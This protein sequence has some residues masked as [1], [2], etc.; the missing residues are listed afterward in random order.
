MRKENKKKVDKKKRKGKEK[1]E[2]KEE[3][4]KRKKENGRRSVAPLNGERKGKETM[5]CTRPNEEGKFEEG[6]PRGKGGTTLLDI[7][8]EL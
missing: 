4:K 8:I 2:Q 1:R 6:T 3:K 5:K 7:G